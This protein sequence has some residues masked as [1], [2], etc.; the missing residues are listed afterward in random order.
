MFA[1]DHRRAADELLRVYRPGVTVALANWTPD[2]FIGALLRTVGQRVPPP[3]G[4][5]PPSLWGTEDHVR[6]LLGDRVGGVESQR[7]EYTFRFDSPEHFTSF[8]RGK[9][10]PHPGGLR[11]ARARRQE[12]ARRRHRGA[13]APLRDK[14][15]GD[16]PVAIPAEYL[17]V[18]ALRAA[19]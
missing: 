18:V 10:R 7:L 12:G 4:V 2:G 13:G 1:P 9:L 15:G 17:E 16:G 11:R 5:A 14:I 19:G 8:F 3:A 6:D